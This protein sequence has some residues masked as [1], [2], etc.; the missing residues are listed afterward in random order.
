MERK[1]WIVILCSLLVMILT[2]AGFCCTKTIPSEEPTQ[3]E[4]QVE[5]YIEVKASIGG[6]IPGNVDA[7]SEEI[8]GLVTA[9]LPVARDIVAKAIKTALLSEF[10]LSVKHTE[11]LEGED[12]YS[13]RVGI[14]FPIL[15]ELPVIGEKEYWVTSY[16]DFTI[17]NGEV[18]DAHIDVSS[19]EMKETTD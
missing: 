10:N 13:A 3:E 14:E 2:T 12:K 9:D 18:T 7:I 1:K 6:W 4:E 16:Y 19:F 11:S 8:G 15:L 5:A 17:D